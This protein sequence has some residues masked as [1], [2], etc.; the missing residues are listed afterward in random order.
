MGPGAR[1]GSDAR[2]VV[3]GAGAPTSGV[4]LSGVTGVGAGAGAGSGVGAIA[5]AS[6]GGK[7]GAGTG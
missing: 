6:A 7:L 2:G 4:K 1:K 5:G 3:V